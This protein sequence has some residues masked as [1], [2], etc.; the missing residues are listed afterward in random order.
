MLSVLIASYN[1][2]VVDLIKELHFQLNEVQISFEIICLDDASKSNL[3]KKNLMVNELSFCSFLE[4]ESNIGRSAIRNLLASK[5]SYDWFLFLDSDVLPTS[6][7]FIS[8]YIKEIKRNSAAVFLGGIKYRDC[9]SKNLLRWKFGKQSEE[10]SVSVRTKNCYKYF[11]TANFLIKKEIFKAI[12][13]NENLVNYGYEDLLF[14][15]ELEAKSIKIIHLENAVFHLGI[16]KNEVFI[17]K[18]KKAIENLGYLIKTNHLQ[19]GDTK[20]SELYFK[21]APYGIVSFLSL[22][23][24]FFEKIANRKASVIFFNLFRITYLNGV[25][26]NGK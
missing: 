2:N 5:A 10:V 12:K 15:K 17:G 21:I 19:K 13:F 1:T 9:D 18:T 8:N 26:K 4:L 6:S 14:S 24:V 3:N 22:F 16:D 20:V 7:N 23:A 11:F 25:I